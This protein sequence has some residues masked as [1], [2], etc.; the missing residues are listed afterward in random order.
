M[1]NGYSASSAHGAAL[2]LLDHTVQA[3]ASTMAYNN[4]FILLGIVIPIRHPAV[5]MLRKP[6]RGA[7]P[8]HGRALKHRSLTRS[9]RSRRG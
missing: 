3:Q 2:G 6:Q 7:A 5:L 9:C 1:G 4:A 8:R